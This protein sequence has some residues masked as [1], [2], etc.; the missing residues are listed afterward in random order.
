MV[1]QN[2]QYSE[3]K[4]NHHSCVRMHRYIQSCEVSAFLLLPC[5]MRAADDSGLRTLV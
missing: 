1:L 2:Q 3:N 5:V 4:V